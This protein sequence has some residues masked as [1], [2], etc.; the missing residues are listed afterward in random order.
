MKQASLFSAERVSDALFPNDF[1]EDLLGLQLF[2]TIRFEFTEMRMRWLI[3][4]ETFQ[5]VIIFCAQ[6]YCMLNACIVLQ[7]GVDVKLTDGVMVTTHR[8]IL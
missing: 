5:T 8:R 3:A 4:D 7:R 1:M 6:L 2:W